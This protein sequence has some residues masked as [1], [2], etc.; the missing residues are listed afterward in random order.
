MSLPKEVKQQ[1]DCAKKGDPVAMYAVA[2]YYLHLAADEKDGQKQDDLHNKALAWLLKSSQ[3]QYLW[4]LGQL[5][6]LAEMR[7]SK[8]SKSWYERYGEFQTGREPQ[9]PYWQLNSQ[10]VLVLKIP[11]NPVSKMINRS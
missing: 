5:A 2:L 4:A 10:K 1:E 11:E 6:I 8:E 7:G 3:K 9:A